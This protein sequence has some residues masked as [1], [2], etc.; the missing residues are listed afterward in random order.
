[1]SPGKQVDETPGIFDPITEANWSYW[2]QSED[3]TFREPVDDLECIYIWIRQQEIN[4]DR[5]T[6]PKI[7]LPDMVLDIEKMTAILNDHPEEKLKLI[8]SEYN[9][10]TRIT[11]SK[12]A[13]GDQF[14]ITNISEKE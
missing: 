5:G 6:S 3:G 9:D 14:D 12:K 7:M 13:I 4:E 1:V 11:K 8:R 10:R 2:V